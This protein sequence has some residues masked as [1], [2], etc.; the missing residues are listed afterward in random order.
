MSI[1]LLLGKM[2]YLC[3][4]KAAKHR[5]AMS[6]RRTPERDGGIGLNPIVALHP[7]FL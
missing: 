7:L 6:K 1:I 4:I 2:Y 5:S 3:D